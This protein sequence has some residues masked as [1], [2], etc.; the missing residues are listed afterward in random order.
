MKLFII[1][2]IIL[3]ALAYFIDWRPDINP[4]IDEVGLFGQA[5]FRY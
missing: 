5:D 3:L 1:G 2:I 4:E